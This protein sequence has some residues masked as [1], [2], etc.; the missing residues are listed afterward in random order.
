MKRKKAP[1]RTPNETESLAP[2]GRGKGP[3]PEAAGRERGVRLATPAPIAVLLRTQEPRV[4]RVSR[5]DPGFL[6]PQENDHAK[7]ST[8]S[9]RAKACIGTATRLTSTSSTDSNSRRTPCRTD[10]ARYPTDNPAT[11]PARTSR[12][13][14]GSATTPSTRNP[15]ASS[16]T[17]D[18]DPT[19]PPR[20]CHNRGTT[21]APAKAPRRITSPARSTTSNTAAYPANVTGLTSTTRQTPASPPAPPTSAP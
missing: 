1:R 2:P 16:A 12:A 18:K 9:S 6:R 20:C 19:E 3:A 17:T 10:V 8:T 14:S 15:R 11:A 21:P 7:T 13:S 4:T 5:L